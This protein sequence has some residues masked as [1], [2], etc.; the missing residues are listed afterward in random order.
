MSVGER[1]KLLVLF[2][3]LVDG[4]QAQMEVLHILLPAMIAAASTESETYSQ[5][6][7]PSPLP[8]RDRIS[9]CMYGSRC[10]SM[11]V[12]VPTPSVANNFCHFLNFVQF[13]QSL[14]SLHASDNSLFGF[15]RLQLG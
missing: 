9:V 4:D 14:T 12:G 13:Q 6:K 1:L 3:S 5:V 2:H 8:Q 11:P 15:S 10:T 7:A